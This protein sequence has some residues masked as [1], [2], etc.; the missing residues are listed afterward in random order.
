[1]VSLRICCITGLSAVLWCANSPAVDER[2]SAGNL[3]EIQVVDDATSRGIPLVELTTV[4]D[5][6]YITDSAGRIALNEPELFGKTVYLRVQS[7]GYQFAKDGFGFEGVRLQLA[8]GQKHELRMTRTQPAERLY[9]ITGRD[10]YL[11]TVRLDHPAPVEHPLLNAN[12]LGQDSIQPALF[13]G[14]IYWFWGD[15]NQLK[16]PLGLY[17]MAGAV[18]DLPESGGL[19]PSVGINLKYFTNEDGFARAMA[20]VPNPEGVVWIHGLAVVPDDSGTEQLVGQF[21]RRRGLTE[22]VEQGMVLWNR[23]TEIFEVATTLDLRDTWRMLRDHPIRQTFDGQ[24]C[25]TFG[26]PFPVTRVPSQLDK[27]LQPTTYESY[28]CREE[29]SDQYPTD[30]Q[31]QAAKPKRDASGKLEWTWKIGPPVT[32]QD[33]Q[34][35]L[36]KGLIQ[37]DEAR[38]LPRDASNPDRIVLMHTGTVQWNAWRQKWVMIANEI[39]ADGNSPSHLGELFYSE[40]DSAQGPY[41]TALKIATHPKQT[42]YN[43]CHHPFFDQNDGRTIYFEG[44]Y[45]NTFT[46]SPPTPRYNYNQL[47]YRLDLDSDPITKAFGSRTQREAGSK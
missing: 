21:S 41:R 19:D 1:M 45:C 3:V 46:H 40:A 12:V 29:L 37:P 8:A 16:Y 5:V 9:R 43:P 33:E 27:I 13:D 22:P 6:T 34:R 7:P 28:S 39:A 36:K 17:R 15:T 18:S 20:T 31:L 35:W 30:Q 47:M 10:V 24:D 4:D 14:K 25:Q 2:N 32:Q 23:T 11:D 44:T 42:F 38:F 26:N